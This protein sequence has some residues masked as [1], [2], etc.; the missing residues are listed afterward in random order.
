MG[1]VLLYLLTGFGAGYLV[2][3]I[4]RF[5]RGQIATCPQ[6]RQKNWVM[7]GTARPLCAACRSPLNAAFGAGESSPV[8]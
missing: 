5:L 2:A 8:R 7:A 4:I 3:L 1:M 6:C